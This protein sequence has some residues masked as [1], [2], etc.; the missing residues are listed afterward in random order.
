MVTNMSNEL[1]WASQGPE[2]NRNIW[3]VEVCTYIRM[4]LF[5]ARI[6]IIDEKFQNKVKKSFIF[7]FTTSPYSQT[8]DIK[9]N[10]PFNE[11]QEVFLS[12][13]HLNDWSSYLFGTFTNSY[14]LAFTGRLTR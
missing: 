2:T 3:V 12:F 11:N 6:R 8:P 13:Q 5:Y 7:P 14:I 10:H 1:T 9:S 4:D